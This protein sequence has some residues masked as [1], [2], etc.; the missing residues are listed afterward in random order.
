MTDVSIDILDGS[1]AVLDHANQLKPF[2]LSQLSFFGFSR[3]LTASNRLVCSQT[4]EL[5]MPR[6]L[7]YFA[8][9]GVSFEL[10]EAALQLSEALSQER[11]RLNT[12]LQL[13]DDFKNGIIDNSNFAAFADFAR[14]R[15][16]RP[17]KQ[18][19]LKA[20]Y[21]LLQVQNGANYSVPGSGKTAV[22]LTVF[23]KLRLENKVNALYVV[24]PPACF[25]PWRNEF[26]LVLGRSP[27]YVVL[28]GGDKQQR[29]DEYYRPSNDLNELY[30]TTY[31]TLGNDLEDVTVLFRNS[32][33]K[34]FLVVDESHYIKQL[35][36]TWAGAVLQL[37]P[38]AE[39]RCALSGTPL[40]RSY[41]DAFNQFEFLWPHNPPLSS[42]LKTSIHL[43]E[44][45]GNWD[46]A[47]TQLR[48][49]I[50]PLFYR[51]R[52]AD[53]GLL[54]QE[55]HPPILVPMRKHESRVYNAIVN[56]I[57][58]LA[59]DDFLRD[60]DLLRIL[61]RG[62]ITRLRQAASYV[63]LLGSALQGYPE[64]I[65]EHGSELC[66]IITNYDSLELPGKLAAL[67]RIIQ[68]LADQRLKAVVWS[69]FVGTINKIA[70]HLTQNGFACK[71]IYG[72]TPTERTSRDVEQTRE[73]IIREFQDPNSGLD[74]L[75]LNPAACA[76]S[77]SLHKTC[78]QAV[79][80]DLS[81]NCAQYLQSLD[82]IHRVGGSEF[83]KADYFFLEYEDTIDQDIRD[84]LDA[85]AQ[86]MLDVIEQDCEVFALDMFEED[87][88]IDAYERL[89]GA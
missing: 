86:R 17:L 59:R 19:Q 47:K 61:R 72:M 11:D 62:R 34:I 25:W 10:T 23:E 60:A 51:V 35:G 76:E 44:D 38:H 56:R 37:A 18:H 63:P 31:Q 41:T 70:A 83:K 20:A 50:D 29:K 40:P 27:R 46:K 58:Q 42:E 84:N 33:A 52:K 13:G 85:K 21:H 43:A 67:Q 81:Y 80:Y 71:R 7:S 12:A 87:D 4:A 68:G 49:A 30:L 53:L 88:G 9:E 69:T 78:F 28:A 57:G 54:A 74:V 64:N 2:Q 22:V 66:S 8:N 3:T 6:L 1:I 48:A 89:F 14:S 5:T 55:F 65:I 82:R 73:S 77:I 15:L 39:Y 32:G 36:G 24:G 16:A 26:E 45:D 79:Y 75:I